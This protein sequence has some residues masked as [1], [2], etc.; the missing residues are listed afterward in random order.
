MYAPLQYSLIVFQVFHIRYFPIFSWSHAIQGSCI[1]SFWRSFLYSSITFTETINLLLCQAFSIQC[2][3]FPF[4]QQWFIHSVHSIS[5]LCVVPY[6]EVGPPQRWVNP[7]TKVNRSPSNKYCSSEC[8]WVC[9]NCTDV[10]TEAQL[11]LHYHQIQVYLILPLPLRVAAES[12]VW[13]PDIVLKLAFLQQVGVLSEEDPTIVRFMT[14]SLRR[15]RDRSCREWKVTEKKWNKGLY[16]VN[17]SL[18]ML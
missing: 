14:S 9:K 5:L 3:I 12:L 17:I 8:R 15:S 11:K 18:I 1:L 7:H 6:W 10:A 16:T 4:S 2:L 13:Y